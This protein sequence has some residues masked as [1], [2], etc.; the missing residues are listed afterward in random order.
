MFDD[1]FQD[2]ETGF[3][4]LLAPPGFRLVF[5]LLSLKLRLAL[6]SAFVL[7]ALLFRFVLL[8]ALG[9]FGLT[10]FGLFLGFLWGCG[11]AITGAANLD[12]AGGSGL[13]APRQ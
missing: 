2:R 8:A 3:V 1:A 9:I 13:G 5:L 4:L 6:G 11:R 12:W 7:K 10:L